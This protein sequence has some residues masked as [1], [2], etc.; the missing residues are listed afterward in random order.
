MIIQPD[1][2]DIKQSSTKC[3]EASHNIAYKNLQGI[4]IGYQFGAYT[5]IGR[6]LTV[7][8]NRVGY[9]LSPGVQAGIPAT[10]IKGQSYNI[11][12]FGESPISDCPQNGAGGFCFQFEKGGYLLAEMYEGVKSEHPIMPVEQPYHGWHSE[13]AFNG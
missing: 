9:T 10:L 6:E 5:L 7:I 8:D 11:K 3:S 13:S 4:A 2:N 12:I 1:E